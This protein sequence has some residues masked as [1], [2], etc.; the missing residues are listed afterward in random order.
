MS[1]VSSF[2]IY[3]YFTFFD[4]FNIYHISVALIVMKLYCLRIKSKYS[5]T[6]IIGPAMWSNYRGG[7]FTEF[8][9]MKCPLIDLRTEIEQEEPYNDSLYWLHQNLLTT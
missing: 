9:K 6:P 1:R 4:S 2:L 3:R 5:E 7:P 8:S